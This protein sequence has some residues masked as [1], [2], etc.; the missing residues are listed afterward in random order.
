MI[1]W[2]WQNTNAA[3]LRQLVALHKL[4]IHP[5][6][7]VEIG[8]IAGVFVTDHATSRQ[9]LDNDEESNF[10]TNGQCMSIISLI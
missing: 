1:C 5:L 2:G 9:C 10:T 8:Y 6:A 3:S 7:V 4:I